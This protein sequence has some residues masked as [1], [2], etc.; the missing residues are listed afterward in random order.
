MI[1]RKNIF[2]IVDLKPEVFENPPTSY[3]H[4]ENHQN[5][6]KERRTSDPNLVLGER[7]LD[8]EILS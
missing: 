7:I 6:S 5:Y 8:S 1:K 3:V 4:K 2:L